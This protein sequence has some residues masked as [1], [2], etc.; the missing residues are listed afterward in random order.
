MAHDQ[1]PSTVHGQSEHADVRARQ[2]AAK[3]AAMAGGL[4]GSHAGSTSGGI[5]GR[6]VWRSIE[7]LADTPE[8]REHLEKEFPHGALEMQRAVEAGGESRRDFLKIMGGSLALAGVAAI[9][10]CR[11]PDHKILPYS[12]EVPEEIIPGKPLFYATSMAR[13]DGG[14]EGLL[15][16]THE[17]RPTK[18]EG[19]PLHPINNGKAS[20]WAIAGIMSLYDPDRLKYPEFVN[21]ARGKVEA[22][23]DDFRAW[24]ATHFK[25]FDAKQGEGLGFIVAK[26]SSPSLEAAKAAVLTKWPKASWAWHAPLDTTAAIRGSVIAFGKPMREVLNLSKANTKVVVSLDRD[27]LYHETDE[28]VNARGFARTREVFTTSDEMSRLYVVE[29]GFSVTGG[30]ADHRLRL[31]PGRVAAFAVELAKFVLPKLDSADAKAIAAAI[32]GVAVPGG[33]DLDGEGKRFLEECAKDLLDAANR[34][35]G[36][37]LA[38]HGQPAEIHALCH[39]I[40]A[41]LGSAGNAV[42][43]QPMTADEAAPGAEQ[44]AALCEKAKSGAIK[45]LVVVNAN[46]AY[47]APGDCDFKAAWSKVGTTITLGIGPSETS[48]ASTWSLNGAH[49]LESWGDSR[50]TDGTIAPVQPM[51][52]PL[53]DPPA[54]KAVLSDLEFLMLLAGK[55]MNARI[56]GY[57]IVRSNWKK[58]L[59]E[60]GFEGAWR[61]ALHDGVLANSARK[62]EPAKIKG[63]DVGRSVAALK[64]GPAPSKDSLD[65]TFT[66]GHLHDGRFSNIAWLHELPEVGTRTVWDTPVLMSP[67]TAEDLG[68]LPAAYSEKDPGAVYTKTKYPEAR[69]AEVSIAGRQATLPCW[70]LPGMADNTLLLVFGG[71]RS[72]SGKVGSGVGVN[73]FP[74]RSAAMVASGGRSASGAKLSRVPGSYMIASTQNHWTMESRTAIVRAVDLP[75]WKKFG[76]ETQKVVDT[77]Y[78]TTG[79]LNFAER[80]GEKS[81]NPPILS[82]YVNPYNKSNSDAKPGST[83]DTGQ[84]WAMTIDQS[85]CTGCGACTIACQAENNIPVV[86]KKETA[87]GREM[88]WIRVDRYF[89][90]DI[91]NPDSMHHQPVACVHCENAP[92]ETVCPVNAT[93][94]GPEGLNYMTY[95][96][97]IGTRY[98]ANNCPYKVRRYN[99]FEYGKLA[100]NGDYVGKEYLDGL[101][102]VIPGQGVGP[103]G[104]PDHNRI[105]VNF[106]PPR[107]R[108]KIAQIEQMQKNPNV[109]VRMRGVMEKCTYCVQRINHARIETKLKGL[110]NSKGEY[111]IPDGFFQSACQQACPTN[112]ITFGDM[113]D[114]GGRVH[115]TRRNARSYQLLGFLNT[116]PRTSH[117]VRVMNPNPALCDAA[118]KDSWEH[119]FHHGGGHGHDDH[120]HG[121]HGDKTH[122]FQF[123]PSRRAEDRGYAL[124]LNVLGGVRA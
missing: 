28:L 108:D 64:I 67:K 45:T 19:N 121:S 37:V 60:A 13:P 38:G 35:K 7:D 102:S 43:Y 78:N 83:F 41:A 6:R 90:G 81:H 124:S 118:R 17:G 39:A 107:L 63:D 47:D 74:L 24:A 92:C 93:V 76:D 29:S 85:L 65:V 113:R 61:R 12:R 10:G 114:E 101:G 116:R 79:E 57:E 52:A 31:A 103:N 40:N 15:V 5:V 2:D 26:A 91:N 27:F 16:E 105:N 82:L 99:F 94:H 1:C 112:A 80:L 58:T 54:G 123:D 56:D 4:S 88:T 44:F 75:A 23:W 100:F 9:P 25:D 14:A 110:K 20:T 68:V 95:N 119:P 69:L 98:C 53:Y 22:T 104:S 122:S 34:A 46:P 51:I 115:A 89:T 3:I 72:S 120:G 48:A 55:D 117:M 97:C 11:R 62:P 84:Q 70:I 73:V 111:A 77:F 106:I 42:T 50:A 86:G 8:F 71:G 96:R 36:I 59:G 18:I 66:V 33:A 109:T 87:K 30:Q 32:N 21:P 49:F